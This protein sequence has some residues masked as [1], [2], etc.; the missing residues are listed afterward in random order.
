MHRETGEFILKT[1]VN[2]EFVA[3]D[4]VKAVQRGDVIVVIDVLRCSST[5]IVALTNGAKSIIPIETVEEA[6]GYRRDHPNF[7]LAGE[8][9]GLKPEPNPASYYMD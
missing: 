7:I 6:R 3:K 1:L 2:L 8:R 5:I 4:A 9:K